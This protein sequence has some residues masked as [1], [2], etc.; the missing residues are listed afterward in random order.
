[1]KGKVGALLGELWK[2]L[3]ELW[4]LLGEP[5]NLL[6]EA[7]Q[8]EAMSSET[9]EYLKTSL[10][11]GTGREENAHGRLKKEEKKEGGRRHTLDKEG[12][13]EGDKEEDKEEEEEQD[14]KED[15][16]ED[17]DTIPSLHCCVGHTA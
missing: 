2:L 12:D 1:M 16:E 6:G 7:W 11:K 15:E 4:K 5:W 14:N 8:R 17:D 3:G 9:T 13:K 10:W